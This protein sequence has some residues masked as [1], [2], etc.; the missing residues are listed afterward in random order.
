M[1]LNKR[2]LGKC[3][4][5]AGIVGVAATLDGAKE[6]PDRAGLSSEAYEQI[7]HESKTTYAGVVSLFTLSAAAFVYGTATTARNPEDIID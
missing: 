5:V 4:A 6:F 7:Y 1:N 2:I 3:I